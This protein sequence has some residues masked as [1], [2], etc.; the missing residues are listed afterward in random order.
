[1]AKVLPLDY[2][3]M[4]PG[5]ALFFHSNLLHRSDQNRSPNARLSLI[6]CFNT[7]RNSPFDDDVHHPSYSPIPRLSDQDLSGI[8]RKELDELMGGA[9]L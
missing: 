1:M 8:G 4:E 6:C 3:E 9:R 2:V 7:A 5:D